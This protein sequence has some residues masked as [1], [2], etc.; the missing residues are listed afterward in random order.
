MLGQELQMQGQDDTQVYPTV[1]MCQTNLHADPGTTAN[2][3]YPLVI[4]GMKQ[5]KTIYIQRYVDDQGM[6]A[7]TEE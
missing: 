7:V 3:R 5:P 1:P 4:E 6:C 2:L